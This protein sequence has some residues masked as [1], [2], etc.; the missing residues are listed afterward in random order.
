MKNLFLLFFLLA[1][2]SA[3]SQDTKPAP[4]QLQQ[5]GATNGQVMTWNNSLGKWEPQTPSSGS[6]DLTFSGASSPVTLAS[7][8]G[9][10]VT[11]TAGTNIT[12]SQ[13]TNNLTINATGGSSPS[14][15]TP[16][17]ITADQDN[18][19]PT[20]WA[21]AT[22]V[23]LS[24]DNGCRAIRGFSA[25]TSGEVKIL[26]NVGS[27]PLYLAPEHASSTAANRIS[28]FEEVFLMP[29]QAC[30]IFYDG[31]LSRWVPYD[32]PNPNY[33]TPRKSVHYDQMPTKVPTAVS[34]NFPLFM[35][36]SIQISNT[37]PTSTIPF[38][39]WDLNTGGTASGGAGI[40]YVREQESMAY[41]GGA[42][43]VAKAIIKSP[44]TLGDATNNYYYFLRLANNPSS[45]FFTQNNST[46][47][48]YRYS[49][50]T[51]KFW[52]RSTNTSGTSTE[53][54]SGVTVAVNTEYELL[55]TVNKA[56]TE[57][58]FFINGSVVGRHTTNLPSAVICGPSTQL[59]KTAGTS[60]RSV[61][62]YRFIGAAIAP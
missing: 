21:D 1:S 11:I 18:Y 37:D 4:V 43:I 31:T 48:Y 41:Y 27:F 16:S 42:H 59:E 2:L 28:C 36:G 35:W 22:L 10:D 55:V 29:G 33:L 3:S 46:G 45:G 60:A 6:T 52:L 40:A 26:S 14:V 9:A 39:A 25:E 24:G 51:G 13:A 23:R 5:A 56:L 19:A 38:M 20:G 12:L 30:E 34:E 58:T 53:T 15:I 32:V 61:Y 44:A 54:D 57:V 49:D 8:T 47:I 50:N 62:I 7:S 17:Q